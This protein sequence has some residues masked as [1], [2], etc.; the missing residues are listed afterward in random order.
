MGLWVSGQFMDSANSPMIT[1]CVQ[2]PSQ[3]VGTQVRTKETY[4]LLTSV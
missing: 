2:S 1:F 3:S 4:S